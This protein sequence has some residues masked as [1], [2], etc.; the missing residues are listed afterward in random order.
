MSILVIVG[1]LIGHWASDL[2]FQSNIEI[3]KKWSNVRAVLK[4]AGKYSVVMS[5]VVLLLLFFTGIL[6]TTWY[7]IL[8]FWLMTYV[9]HFIVDYF[10]SKVMNGLWD[11]RDRIGFFSIMITDQA[12]HLI[13][14]FLTISYLFY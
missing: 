6:S 1:V 3:E 8:N 14:L 11:K 7:F 13:T 2:I 12:I 9:F 10:L 5:A 4:H